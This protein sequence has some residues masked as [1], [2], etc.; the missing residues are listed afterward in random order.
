MLLLTKK[1]SHPSSIFLFYSS[2]QCTGWCLLTITLNN[3]FN[4]DY[5]KQMSFQIFASDYIRNI[6]ELSGH[7]K[8]AL[9]QWFSLSSSHTIH[10]H[11]IFLPKGC[12]LTNRHFQS[13]SAGKARN[14][15]KVQ[16]RYEVPEPLPEA[17]I[18]TC[19][20]S[21]WYYSSYS[22]TNQHQTE[23]ISILTNH[24]FSILSMHQ[25]S[26]IFPN[27]ANTKRLLC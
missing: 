1:Q 2:S 5:D 4:P 8:M 27:W 18:S 9:N 7:D 17:S 23:Q 20:D 19:F 16:L 12:F 26:A 3:L 24:I 6:S 10:M 13:Q 25:V 11:T 22:S 21:Y 15:L 14:I